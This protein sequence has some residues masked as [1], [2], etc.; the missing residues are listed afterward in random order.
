MTEDNPHLLAHCHITGIGHQ[1][2]GIQCQI[3]NTASKNI[4]AII[5]QTVPWFLQVYLHTFKITDEKGRQTK[6]GW[7]IEN[8][9]GTRSLT[10]FKLKQQRTDHRKFV[11]FKGDFM[12]WPIGTRGAW[13]L[14]MDYYPLQWRLYWISRSRMNHSIRIKKNKFRSIP[15]DFL[16]EELSV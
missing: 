16:H 9:F 6:A 13:F 14:L 8:A 15:Q 5:M 11:K 1:D 7:S 10:F 12:P 2:G 3:S 4:S